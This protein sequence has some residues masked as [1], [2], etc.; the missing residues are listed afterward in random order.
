[1]CV[2]AYHNGT[3][4]CARARGL[5]HADMHTQALLQAVPA[6]LRRVS[7]RRKARSQ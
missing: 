3:L 6:K 2:L 5:T 7:T 1:M 4:I